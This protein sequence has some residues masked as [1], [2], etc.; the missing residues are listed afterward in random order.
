MS[1]KFQQHCFEWTELPKRFEVP[2]AVPEFLPQS[3]STENHQRGIGHPWHYMRDGDNAQPPAVESIPV[4]PLHDEIAACWRIPRNPKKRR[5]VLLERLD[6]ER[7][8]LTQDIIR[9]RE[10]VERGV[11]ALS[12]YDREIVYGGNDELPRAS[13]IALKCNHIAFHKTR[14]AWIERELQGGQSTGVTR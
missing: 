13:T 5:A 3:Q 10:I 14:I 8:E 6:E 11:E 9:Y 1:F 2:V 12:R 4:G 7:R